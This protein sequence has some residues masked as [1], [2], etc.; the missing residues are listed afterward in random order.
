MTTEID[1]RAQL[2][3]AREQGL[4]QGR[5]EGLAEGEA[6]GKA[7]GRAEG[8]AEGQ[9]ETRTEIARALLAKGMSAELVKEVTGVSL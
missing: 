9:A 8:K 2:K 6:K 7:E 3:Y 4:E 1:K 5:A